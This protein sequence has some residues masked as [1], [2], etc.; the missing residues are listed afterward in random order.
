MSELGSLRYF[1]GLEIQRT[2]EG[3]LVTQTKY[4]CDLLSKYGMIGAKPC[5][6]PISLHPPTTDDTPCSQEDV[7]S[8]QTIIGSLHYLTFSRP[9]IAFSVSK[10]SQFMHLPSHSHLVA[11]KRILRYSCGN[12]FIRFEFQKMSSGASTVNCLF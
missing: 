6:S 4:V 7:Q 12:T 3:I 10:L 9:D 1:L 5:A 11:A 8:Y 2:I